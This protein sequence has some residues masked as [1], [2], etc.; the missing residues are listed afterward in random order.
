MQM[1][2]LPSR[3]FLR[4]A[5]ALL[6]VLLLHLLV[7]QA[8]RHPGYLT[9]TTK[10][11]TAVRYLQL[12]N[13]PSPPPVVPPAPAP[14]AQTVRSPAVPQHQAKPP[15]VAQVQAAPSQADAPAISLLP[16]DE[17][18]APAT[19]PAPAKLDL[20][21]LRKS[22]IAYEKHHRPSEIE[23]MQ[24]GLRRDETL[25]K[26]LGDRV[27]KAKRE[28]CLRSY[29]GFGLLAVIPLAVSTV[30]DTGCNW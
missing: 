5:P 25:E 2:A 9:P 26:H 19:A 27:D 22:A 30:V 16:P 18:P 3:Q 21:A 20:D 1:R 17:H 10:T 7:W 15:R 11:E 4:H 12:L 28:D 14:L 6:L 24:A 8:L 29:S 13:I 23:Q